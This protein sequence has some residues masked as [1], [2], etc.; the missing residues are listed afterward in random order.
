MA[1]EDEP[2]LVPPSLMMNKEMPE[3]PSPSKLLAEAIHNLTLQEREKVYEDIHGVSEIIEET[4]DLIG[5]S[6]VDLDN[7]LLSLNSNNNNNKEEMFAYNKA[8]A[9]SKDYVT[10]STFRLSFLRAERF[11]CNKAASRI[12][13]HFELKLKVF[14]EEKLT[15]PIRLSDLNDKE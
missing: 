13:R 5:Q 3:L 9:M 4:S 1:G 11:N 2:S 7:E 12:V 10:D 6:L 8:L 14:G 15:K